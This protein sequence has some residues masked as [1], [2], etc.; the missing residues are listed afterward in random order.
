MVPNRAGRAARA[1]TAALLRSPAL[2]G[3]RIAMVTEFAYPVLGG[4]SEHVHHLSRKL[5]ALGH[6]VTVVTGRLPG[7]APEESDRALHAA[8]GY[9]T[10]RVGRS[11]PVVANKSI[12]A[13]QRRGPPAAPAGGDPR[14][15]RRRARAGAGRA[16]SWMVEST[17]YAALDLV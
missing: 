14:R 3:L 17:G 11:V 2:P 15:R 8:D 5:V 13:G 12:G 16:A 9:R 1:G 7:R 6:E 10:V 4:V